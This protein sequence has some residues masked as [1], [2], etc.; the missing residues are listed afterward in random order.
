MRNAEEEK[1]YLKKWKQGFNIL[2]A[3]GIIA[4]LIFLVLSI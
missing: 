1:K 3:V 4:L 2:L